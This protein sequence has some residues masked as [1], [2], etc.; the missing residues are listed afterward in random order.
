LEHFIVVIVIKKK[1]EQQSRP[2]STKR[3]RRLFTMSKSNTTTSSTTP[4]SKSD[5]V[6]ESQSAL[7]VY[8]HPL[9]IINIS[10]HYTRA[11]VQRTPDDKK[12]P[13]V[14]GAL[15][16][17]Q[18]GRRVEIRTS[19]EFIYTQ[20]DNGTITLDKEYIQ[21]KIEQYAQVFKNYEVLGWYS[22]GDT[23]LPEDAYIHQQV[24]AFNDSP[25][26][27]LCGVNLKNA[28]DIPLYI[29]ESK[30]TISKDNESLISWAEISYKIET[31]ESER[32]SVDFVNR[33]EKASSEVSALV[34]HFTTLC[35]AVEMLNNR[36]QI[37]LQYLKSV[38]DGKIPVNHKVMRQITSLIHRLPAVDSPKFTN[39]Y[40]NELNETLM[41]T[42]MAVITKGTNQLNDV[43]DKFN[44]T[45]EK[46]GRRGMGL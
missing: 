22:T 15:Y 19:F 39:E 30:V 24:M 42:Y 41:I 34:P 28:K 18:E 43:V 44:T 7:D 16:G 36:I 46:R 2:F 13:R 8:L 11:K 14:I 21:Q 31:E 23:I 29:Y 25:L 6:E 3:R 12:I 17:T 37:L 32:I 4:S 9:V 10:D 33:M 40:I 1:Q 5:K 45:Y 27:L 38:K 26:F 35:N 20:E